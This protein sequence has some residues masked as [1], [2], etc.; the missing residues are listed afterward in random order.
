LPASSS[1]HQPGHQND[2][3]RA[4]DGENQDINRPWVTFLKSPDQA[5][6]PSHELCTLKPTFP[7]WPVTDS[8]AGPVEH[9]CNAPPQD[10]K[11][12]ASLAGIQDFPNTWA[13]SRIMFADG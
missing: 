4:D 13:W 3:G 8:I 6:N 12:L 1:S 7:I 11:L 2:D 10:F 5:D 9:Q